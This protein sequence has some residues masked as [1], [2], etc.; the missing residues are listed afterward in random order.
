[1]TKRLVKESFSP[2]VAEIILNGFKMILDVNES[3]RIVGK[4]CFIKKKNI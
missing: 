1:M 4:T 3:I 2:E